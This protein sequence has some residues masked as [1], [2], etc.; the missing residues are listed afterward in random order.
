MIVTVAVVVCKSYKRT[1]IF[2]QLIITPLGWTALHEACSYG[3]HQVVEVL[4]EGGANVNAKGLDDDTPL[5]DASTSGNLKMVQY[6]IDHGADPFVKNTKG[7]MPADYA[8]PH[9]QTY[10]QS[11]KGW[12]YMYNSDLVTS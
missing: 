7:K 9:I 11:L 3:W 1:I 6:L 2:S 5:H 8:A 10:L 4:V 12:Y